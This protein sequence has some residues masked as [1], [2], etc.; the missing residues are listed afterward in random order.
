[1][2]KKTCILVTGANG[3]LGSEFLARFSAEKQYQVK[4]FNSN[5]LDI[6][7][8]SALHDAV[9]EL[10]PDLFINCAAYTKVDVAENDSEKCYQ[11]NEIGV[12]HLGELCAL[13]KA[14]LLHFSTDYVFDGETNMAY[15][16]T[17]ICNP[18]NV[19]GASKLAGEKSLEMTECNYM[20]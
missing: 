5:E 11:V 3:Q 14:L 6:T 9:T 19:Y 18:I 1:M 8:F 12:K 17:D 15:S 4:S 16:E 7:D 13:N 2:K 20:V 10:K